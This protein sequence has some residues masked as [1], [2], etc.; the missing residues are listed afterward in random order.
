[1]VNQ[2]RSISPRQ[3]NLQLFPVK[4]VEVEGVAMEFLTMERHILPAEDWLK[5]VACIIV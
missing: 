1:M 2:I 4:E 5:C 3:G